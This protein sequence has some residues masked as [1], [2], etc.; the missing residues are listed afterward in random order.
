V[1]AGR[2]TLVFK[3]P[4]RKPYRRKVTIRPGKTTRLGFDLP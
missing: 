4:G 1:P 2:H 3:H